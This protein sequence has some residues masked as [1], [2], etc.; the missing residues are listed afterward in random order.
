[1]LDLFTRLLYATAFVKLRPLN[2]LP[3]ALWHCVHASF[4]DVL[5]NTAER[6][7]QIRRRAGQVGE[8]LVAPGERDRAQDCQGSVEQAF[9]HGS[10]HGAVTRAALRLIPRLSYFH[11]PDCGPMLRR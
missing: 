6:R 4:E 2:R 3:I 10:P 11:L 7:L 1:M 9:T 8:F 5:L